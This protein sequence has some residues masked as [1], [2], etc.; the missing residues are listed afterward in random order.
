MLGFAQILSKSLY[1]DNLKMVWH[2]KNHLVFLSASLHI[3]VKGPSAIF[4]SPLCHLGHYIPSNVCYILTNSNLRMRSLSTQSRFAFRC[5]VIENL[6]I[7]N[8]QEL[9]VIA[10]NVTLRQLARC[11]DFV[12]NLIGDSQKGLE[13]KFR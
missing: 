6:I 12:A 10:K 4:S 1:E 3:L 11:C 9:K 2:S 7:S 8:F 13:K 5:S